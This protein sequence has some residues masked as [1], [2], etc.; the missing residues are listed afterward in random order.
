MKPKTTIRFAFPLASALAALLAIS[1]AHAASLY[2]DIDDATAGAGGTA[3]AGSWTAGGTTW[4]TSPNGS[5][6]TPATTTGATDD[7]FFSA[8]VNA[9]GAYGITLTDTQNAGSLT[10]QDGTATIS[11]A[12]GVITLG[13]TG[14]VNVTNSLLAAPNTAVIGANTDTL[15]DGSTGLTKVG[16]GT[17]T[18]NGTA[19]NTF[20]G[21]LIVNGG[22]LGLNFANLVTPTDLINTGNTLGLGGG[23]LSITGNAAGTTIQTL[24]NVTINSGGGSILVNPN[25][26]TA[27]NITLGSLTTTA[28]GGSLAVGKALS[29]GVGTT[30]ITTT[31]DK[32][33]TTGIYGGRVVFAD[34]TANTGYDWATTVDLASPFGLSAYAGYAALDTVTVGNVTDTANSRITAGA[35][36]PAASNRTTN[37]LKFEN[38]LTAQILDLVAGNTLTLSSGGLLFT[39]AGVAQGPRINN[40]SITAG[41]GSGSYD[42]VVHQYNASST[43]AI[44]SIGSTINNNT[45]INSNIGN[46]GPDAVTLVKNGPGGL[47]VGGANTFTGGIV[48]NQGNVAFNS[49]TAINNNAITFNAN[50]TVHTFGGSSTSGNITLN[51]G[52]QV[53]ILNNNSSFTVTGNVLGSG[54]ISAANG[55]QGAI[56]LNLSGTGNTF[57]GPLRI[58]HNNGTQAATINVGSL[59]DTDTLGSGN[60]T[61][62]A[63][64]A[65]SI[66]HTFGLS[67]TAIAP[68]IL[69]NRRFEL[70][71][72]QANQQINN[73]SGQALTVNNDLLVVGSRAKNLVLGSTSTGISTFAGVIAN[74]PTPTAVGTVPIAVRQTAA[75]AAGGALTL[76]SVEGIVA[77]AT[78]SGTGIAASTTIATVNP[79]TRQ[80]TLSLATTGGIAL[81][82]NFTIPGVVN[83]IS[84]NKAG[85]GTG[86]WVLSGNNTYT[87]PTQLT[88]GA[89]NLQNINALGGTGVGTL[90]ANIATV[91]LQGGFSYAAEP[92]IFAPGTAGSAMLHNISDSN[93]WNGPITSNTAT[94]TNVSR[95]QSDAGTMTLAGFITISGSVHQF[96]FQGNGAITTTGQITGVGRVTSG[97]TGTGV[98]TVSNDS[99]NFTGAVNVNGGTL[100]FTSIDNVGAASSALGAP[101]LADATI[102]LA[103]ATTAGALRYVGTAGGGHTSDRVINLASTTGAAT[104]EANGTGPLVF[105]SAMTA[106]GAGIKTLTLGGSNT[107]NNTLG[108]AIV[109]NSVTNITSLSKDGAGKWILSGANTYT[110]NTTVNTGTLELAD[111]AQLKFVLGAASGT[112]NSIAGAGTVTLEGDFVID[113][114]AANALPAG[115]SW[116]LEN[117]GSLPGAYG[118]NFTVVGF[119]NAGSDTW[120]KANGATVYT[121]DETTGI[122]TLSAAGGYS[123]WQAANGTGLAIDLDHDGDGVPNGV[124]YFLFGSG[125]STGFT[126]LPTVVGNTVT[127][128]KAA[129]G[130]SGN[131]TTDFV[132]ETSSTLIGVW[133]TAALGANPG[134]VVISGNDVIYTFPAGPRNF[135]RLKVTG[136]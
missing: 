35:A 135:A 27:T 70:A 47:L 111:N 63:G 11:G 113:T 24:G 123:S 18:L 26:G 134:E 114:T 129:V 51:N 133:G 118:A 89:L 97:A 108:G 79:F 77:G 41:N 46:N 78:I 37:S 100:A 101:V 49:A 81:G 136:P 83:S 126:A 85:A 17:L 45:T 96:V 93:T 8:G 54:G 76:A 99:N 67:S 119:T 5:V 66:N 121:F 104:I 106:T 53:T 102:Q 33:A 86:A 12:S 98:R 88:G 110:G 65:S 42:L 7:L 120:T 2:W 124:E 20:T 55:G 52:S 38:P 127:W 9:T 105:T 125:N 31:T 74:H 36:V 3:P 29:A 19:V 50:S 95:I 92:L 68:L 6:A 109:D 21:G 28:S 14:I 117:V 32:D 72:D 91:Q 48:I 22:T 59:V 69:N 80:V 84:V 34:G 128:T 132:V 103:A 116:T 25:G 4:G 43:I 115:S 1:N 40:G 23:N 44:G 112:N 61:F 56:T 30:T 94:G 15:I 57:T 82:T 87:G 58:T 131:Y 39:G 73:A 64:T 10:F 75:V 13:G 60:I 130:Y 107:G 90:V 122:L 16:V 71:G 62:G